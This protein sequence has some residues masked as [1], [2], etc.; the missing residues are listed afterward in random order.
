MGAGKTWLGISPDASVLSPSSPRKWLDDYLGSGSIYLGPDGHGSHKISF[1]ASKSFDIGRMEITIGVEARCSECRVASRSVTRV[2]PTLLR[3][4]GPKEPY[5]LIADL[6]KSARREF[7]SLPE[8][9]E[10]ALM[11]LMA[12]SVLE[13]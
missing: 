1:V 13:S 2:N 7:H 11:L 6:L 10:E 4:G 5:V 12:R 9:C 8:T 3:A